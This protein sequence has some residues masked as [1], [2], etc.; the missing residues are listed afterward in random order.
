MEDHAHCEPSAAFFASTLETPCGAGDT[1]AVEV[2]A[3]A[4]SPIDDS[5]DSGAELI[6]HEK[7]FYMKYFIINGMFGEGGNQIVLVA[8][9]R[10]GSRIPEYARYVGMKGYSFLSEGQRGR[11][12]SRH[13][14]ER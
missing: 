12:P 5:T 14:E 4:T 10:C 2:A 7:L 3:E 8:M 1:G 6:W 11:T 9:F 13:E